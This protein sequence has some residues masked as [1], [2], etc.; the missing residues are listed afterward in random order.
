MTPL[1]QRAFDFVRDR[2]T[3]AGYSPTAGEIMEELEL[4]SEGSARNLIDA[5]VRM[6]KLAKVA[7]CT[8]NL[9]IAGAPDLSL[10]GTGAL[11]AELARRGASLD[12]LVLKPLPANVGRP[13]AASY[14]EER[15][16]P[17]K[18]MC[19]DHWLALPKELREKIFAAFRARRTEEYGELVRQAIELAD[20]RVD[21]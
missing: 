2:I 18:L 11:R 9:A 7:G 15:V 21:A 5:L 3:E 13:C 6:K 16:K 4:P 10:V 14:C 12:A 19:R 1:Q 20:T 8:R 17:G